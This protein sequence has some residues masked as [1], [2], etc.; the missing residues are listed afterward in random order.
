MMPKLTPS[1]AYVE[2]VTIPEA[3]SWASRLRSMMLLRK[4]PA[5]SDQSLLGVLAGGDL[6][7]VLN[8]DRLAVD[9]LEDAHRLGDR[10]VLGVELD[11]SRRL[12]VTAVQGVELG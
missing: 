5:T 8:L 7:D 10:V 1:R 11:L 4:R 2:P 3:V 9:D 12:G 6:H